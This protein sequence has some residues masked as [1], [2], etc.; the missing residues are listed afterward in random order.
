MKA[1]VVETD[2]ATVLARSAEAIERAALAGRTRHELL[3]ALSACCHAI[4]SSKAIVGIFGNAWV[5]PPLLVLLA[6]KLRRGGRVPRNGAP[7]PKTCVTS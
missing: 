2:C 7:A 1:A 6:G 4:T 3:E 5:R